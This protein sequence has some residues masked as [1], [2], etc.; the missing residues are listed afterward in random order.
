M[1]DAPSATWTD[2]TWPSCTTWHTDPS[3]LCLS[4][5]YSDLVQPRSSSRPSPGLGHMPQSPQTPTSMSVQPW[6]AWLKRSML[7]AA[8]SLGPMSVPVQ[9]TA[10]SYR[11]KYRQGIAVILSTLGLHF[12]TQCHFYRRG[13]QFPNVSY[14]AKRTLQHR[15]CNFKMFL[16]TNKQTF[17]CFNLIIQ[18]VPTMRHQT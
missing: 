15:C 8:R 16:A 14:Q 3:Y 2:S 5:T 6:L 10:P 13:N 9:P 18:L 12:L 7:W 4:R 17:C 11:Q 1:H